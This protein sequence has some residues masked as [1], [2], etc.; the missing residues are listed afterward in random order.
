MSL[1]NPPG[2][3]D[4]FALRPEKEQ[5]LARGWDAIVSYWL[6][7]FAGREGGGFYNFRTDRTPGEPARQVLSWGAF[8]RPIK[9]WFEDDQNADRRRWT[10][11]DTLRPLRIGGQPLRRVSDNSLAEPVTVLYRQQDEYCEWFAHRDADGRID[12]VT[13]TTESPEYWT[14]L[15][16]GT[17]PFF[18]KEDDRALIADGD[19]E[20]VVQLYQT[21]VD[22]SVTVEDL[23]WPFDVA[24]FDAREDRW[25]YHGRAGTYNPHN[26]WTTTDGAMHLTHPAN[27]IRGE[28]VVA[29]RAAVLRQSEAGAPIHDSEAVVCCAGFGDPNRSSDPGIGGAVNGLV[30]DGYGVSLADPVGLYIPRINLG[31]FAGPNGEYPGAAWHVDRGDA[32]RQMTLRATFAPPP[33]ANFQVEEILANG[34]PISFGGQIADQVS[35]ALTGLAKRREAEPLVPAGC[36]TKCCQHP[37][38]PNVRAVVEPGLDCAATD[39]ESLAP[40]EDMVS[41]R[42]G[43]DAPPSDT[44]VEDPD[45]TD[46]LSVLHR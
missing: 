39:W 29:S 31:A 43:D 8:P 25:Y 1:L 24:A 30:R 27:T 34:T 15:A 4:D 36:T 2:F 3:L 38:L 28:F 7:R 21:F 33:G 5:A 16:L 19:I 9:K 44:A 20:L 12:R 17:R 42:G 45:P 14:F 26:K 40:V 35:V 37:E 10:A 23:L 41:P 18:P 11:A 22:P 32:Q 6:E 13:F 46:P